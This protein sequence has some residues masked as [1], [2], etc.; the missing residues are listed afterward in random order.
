V[1]PLSASRPADVRE[2]VSIPVR[3]RTFRKPIPAVSAVQARQVAD[4]TPAL[5]VELFEGKHTWRT[6][7]PECVRHTDTSAD[8]AADSGSYTCQQ[9]EV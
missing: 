6:V 3:R 2:G 9:G 5:V 8:D 7:C 1:C 4:A